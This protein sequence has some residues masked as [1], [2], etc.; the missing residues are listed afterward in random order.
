MT[1]LKWIFLCLL[2][3]G[4]TYAYETADTKFEVSSLS[5]TK[6]QIK[7]FEQQTLI[8]DQIADIQAPPTDV[9]LPKKRFGCQLQREEKGFSFQ[10]R[11]IDLSSLV[12]TID[13]ACNIIIPGTNETDYKQG[14]TWGFK[15]PQTI[16]NN[17]ASAFYKAFT[18]AKALHNFGVLKALTGELHQNYLFNKGVIHFGDAT[19]YVGMDAYLPYLSQID[20]SAQPKYESGVIDD[21]GSILAE[22]GIKT[23]GLKHKSHV[24]TDVGDKLELQNASIENSGTYNVSGPITGTAQRIENHS[25]FSFGSMNPSTF[26][27]GEWVND[28]DVYA[29]SSSHIFATELMDNKGPV[30]AKGDLTIGSRRRPQ[31]FGPVLA[32][33]AIRAIVQDILD[34]LGFQEAF[35]NASFLS[36]EQKVVHD[37]LQ[38][39]DHYLNTI[40]DH[41]V[42]DQFGGKRFSHRT[43]TGYVF[44]RRTTEKQAKEVS[45]GGPECAQ[46]IDVADKAF[47]GKC[48]LFKDLRDKLKDRLK[49]LAKA[50]GGGKAVLGTIAQVLSDAGLTDE[51]IAAVLGDREISDLF[52]SFAIYDE[53][54]SGGKSALFQAE[55]PHSSFFRD[56]ITQSQRLGLSAVQWIQH[57]GIEIVSGFCDL[58]TMSSTYCKH[59]VVVGAAGL[60][61][62]GRIG[63]KAYQG[64][65]KAELFFSKRYTSGKGGGIGASQARKQEITSSTHWGSWEDYKKVTLNGKEYA[66][67]GSRLYTRHAVDYM[68]PSGLGRPASSEGPGRSFPPNLVEEVIL[69]GSKRV[70]I[71]DG[72]E[73]TIHS[74]GTAEVITE[75]GGQI[76][77]TINPFR[78]SH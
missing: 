55:T 38:H 52:S 48:K 72:V 3:L 65:R 59:P 73:R 32:E 36:K 27:L 67:V 34:D 51:D 16:I 37:I 46:A 10:Y 43:E 15:T 66:E 13:D 75:N 1:F 28:G 44:Q 41:Y 40:T 39:T 62:A 7:V 29:Q 33:G 74:S 20:P 63:V 49:M 6:L 8:F 54:D 24:Y 50:S 5:P 68:Q 17:G 58:A 42:T 9:P 70:V 69:H 19:D 45:V 14:K 56:V 64:L 71:R 4:S 77:I 25:F 22:H 2:S 12:L 21:Y 47:G 53:L 30:Y 18:Q 60:C 26:S 61:G 57:N 11:G 78:G 23:T 31:S 35:K 76:V